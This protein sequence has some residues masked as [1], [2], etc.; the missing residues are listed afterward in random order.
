MLYKMKNGLVALDTSPHLIPMTGIA[1]SVHPHKYL[2]PPTKTQVHQY[3]FY[4]RTI[5]QWNGLPAEVALVPTL[6][7]FKRRVGQMQHSV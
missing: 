1:A 6:D 4:P 3:S 2:V 5:M 7:A